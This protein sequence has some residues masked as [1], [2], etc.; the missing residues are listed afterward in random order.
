MATYEKQL[1]RLN[2]LIHEGSDVR[3]TAHSSEHSTQSFVDEELFAKW[4][5]GSQAFLAQVFG[6]D[7]AL[8]QKFQEATVSNFTI[9]AVEGHG[10]LKGARRN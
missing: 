7:N 9:R 8:S 3:A 4:A 6:K 2:Q 10:I 1:A 5:A